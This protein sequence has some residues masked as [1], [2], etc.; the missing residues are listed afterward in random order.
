MTAPRV[1]T[2]LIKYD[3]EAEALGFHST[4][5][6]EA[7]SPAPLI[8]LR[9]CSAPATRRLRLGTAGIVL[10]WHNP[11]L[12]SEQTAMLDLSY[13]G[14]LDPGNNE[15]AGFNRLRVRFAVVMPCR[16]ALGHLFDLYLPSPIV[17]LHYTFLGNQP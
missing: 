3:T 15:V 6:V 14:R 12:M 4:L 10:P 16:L 17:L 7:R 2:T 8:L 11:V 1:S 13:A 5:A 9:W